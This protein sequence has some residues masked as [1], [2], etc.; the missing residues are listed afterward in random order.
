MFLE[1][2]LNNKSLLDLSIRTKSGY[3]NNIIVTR[4]QLGYMTLL[5]TKMFVLITYPA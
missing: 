4:Y 2:I 5:L 1:C 3:L